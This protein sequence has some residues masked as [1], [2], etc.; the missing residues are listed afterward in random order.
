MCALDSLLSV[1][2]PEE[3]LSE[4][5]P[6][7]EASLSALAFRLLA[8]SLPPLA[9]VLFWLVLGFFAAPVESSS[10]PSMADAPEAPAA[11]KPPPASPPQ[12]EQTPLADVLIQTQIDT[13]VNCSVV[14]TPFVDALRQPL[15][16]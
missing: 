11:P 7:F 16:I 5:E 4:D 1:D 13:H 15:G 2:F 10:R 3:L 6:L 12:H 8:S 9:V 14:V